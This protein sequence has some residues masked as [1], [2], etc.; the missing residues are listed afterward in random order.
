MAR[1]RSIS[2][3]AVSTAAPPRSPPQAIPTASAIAAADQCVRIPFMSDLP[4]GVVSLLVKEP[5][6]LAR[7]IALLPLLACA[8]ALA[9]AAEDEPNWPQWRGPHRNGVSD[10]TDLP[11]SFTADDNLL[12]KVPVEGRGHSSPRGLGRTDLPDDR[13]RGRGASRR[14]APDAR[15]WRGAVPAPRVA[16]RGPPAHAAR[17]VSGRPDRRDDLVG[18]RARRTG[19][20]QPPPREHLRFAHRRHRR[21][22]RL[23]LLRLPGAVRLRRR[24]GRDAGSATSATSRPGDTGTE[25]RRSCTGTR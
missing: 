4:C 1:A 23:F 17:P 21:R 2:A 13:R 12:W 7:R 24:R 15:P 3:G 5:L 10:A 6:K 22:A 20:R 9:G 25:R 16:E 19:L 18:H 11:V 8:P 14:R